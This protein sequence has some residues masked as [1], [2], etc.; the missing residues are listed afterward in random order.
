[1]LLRADPVTSAQRVVACA[2]RGPAQGATRRR[3]ARDPLCTGGAWRVSWAAPVVRATRAPVAGQAPQQSAGAGA[4][5]ALMRARISHAGNAALA[6]GR[7]GGRRR[8]GAGGRAGGRP[9]A[10]LCGR[11][12]GRRARVRARARAHRWWPPAPRQWRSLCLSAD[13]RGRS[14]GLRGHQ[15]SHM[16]RSLASSGRYHHTP[17]IACR[18]GRLLTGSLVA[19][20]RLQTERP[21]RP[22]ERP[23]RPRRQRPARLAPQRAAP[24]RPRLRRRPPRI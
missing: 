4:A 24:A 1:M 13:T 16:L 12:G 6:A 3:S 7:A 10:G 9:R 8:R 21:T 20:Q 18:P 5:A 14:W 2:R 23:P 11:R 19:P 15:H 17:V 22:G